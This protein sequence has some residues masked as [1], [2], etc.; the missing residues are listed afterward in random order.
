MCYAVMELR[1][2]MVGGCAM[3]NNIVKIR[4]ELKLL[5]VFEVF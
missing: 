1:Q 5:D 2:R 4:E 3:G